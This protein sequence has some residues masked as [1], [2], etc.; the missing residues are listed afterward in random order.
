M[1]QVEKFK[2]GEY[3]AP[4][5]GIISCIRNSITYFAPHKSLYS[6]I[7]H[8]SYTRKLYEQ[9][10]DQVLKLVLL[11]VLQERYSLRYHFDHIR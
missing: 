8:L 3:F 5:V 2:R 11:E 1:R 10:K 6:F 7:I 4:V 9:N